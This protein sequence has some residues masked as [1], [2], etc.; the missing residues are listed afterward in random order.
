MAM[1]TSDDISDATAI[2]FAELERLGIATLRCGVI[3]IDETR[4]MDAWTAT[5]TAENH[6]VRIVGRIDM[7][8]HPLLDGV[9]EAWKAEQ[10]SFVYELAGDDMEAYYQAIARQAAYQ[11]PEQRRLSPRQ[12]CSA[13]FFAEGALFA[14][15][16]HPLTNQ[17]H[18][19]FQRFA[20]VFALTYRRYL[21]L[22]KAEEQAREAQIEAALERVRARAMGMHHS[23]ELLGVVA[24]MF[25]EME[26]L[27][28]EPTTCS[29]GIFDAETLDSVWW[30]F[31]ETQASIPRGYRVPYFDHPWWKAIVAAW[32]DRVPFMFF[33]GAGEEKKRFDAFFFTETDAKDLPEASKAMITALDRSF[34][35]YASM[36]HGMLEIN[37]D[38]PLPDDKAD[39]LQ[40]FAKVIDLT[41]TRFDD[42]QQAEARAREATQAAALDRVRAEIASMRTADDLQRITPLIWRELTTLGVPFFRCGVFIVDEPTETTQLFLTNPEGKALAALQLGFGDAPLVDATVAHWRRGAVYT[43]EWDAARMHD[44]TQFLQGRGLIETSTRY[45]DAEAPPEHLALHFV[46]FE[47]GMLYVGS[48]APL[49]AEAID[50]VQ[51]LADAFAVAYARYEDFQRLEA[52]KQEVEAALADL[53][54]AQQQLVHAEKMAS[55]GALTAGIAHEIKNPLNFINNF[56]ALSRELADDLQDETDPDEIQALLADLRTN[57]EKIEHHGKRA[58]GIVRAMMQ[59]AR[60]GEG[61]REAVD[62]N[63]LVAEYLDLAYH[64]KRAQTPDFNAEITKDLGDDVGEVEVVPQEIGRVLLNLIGNAFDAVYEQATRVNGQY[65]PAVVV[66]TRRAGDG[67]EIRV[68]DNGPGIAE[69]VRAKIFEP[70]FTTKPTGSGTGLGLSLSYDIV[71][72]GHGGTLTVESAPGEGAAFVVRLPGTTISAA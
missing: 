61:R 63:A 37:T 25:K 3:I 53:K 40:R 58:D 34:V 38:A 68:A 35:S 18:Q 50:T 19:I 62:L 54:A 49:A 29:I 69:A 11:L 51:A 39:I 52:K 43:E 72:Q 42:L 70:F 8:V 27:G 45:L 32:Q 23:E 2:V 26:H 41:Y 30:Q 22:K 44:W 48:R 71:T 36:N 4:H 15:S 67:V 64:G 16:E 33:E 31:D 20:A 14:F 1:H 10:P 59:H 5:A 13:F 60:G 24:V 7:T 66:S 12:I 21:D 65:A 55:L 57:A 47:Q 56:A 6:D 28:F 9:F 46:P 17:S